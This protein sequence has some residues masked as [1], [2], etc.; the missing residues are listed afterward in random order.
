[1]ITC[2]IDIKGTEAILVCLS[3]DQNNYQQISASI[4]KFK[5][6]DSNNQANVRHFYSTLRQFMTENHFDK[7]GIKERATKGKFA[8][9]PASFKIEGLIQTLD[10]PVVIVHGRTVQA[11]LKTLDLNTGGYSQYQLDALKLAYFL[12]CE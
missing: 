12:L 1:M 5:L 10:I 2:G 7:I 4:K 3:G 9:G 6:G 8:G 11:K